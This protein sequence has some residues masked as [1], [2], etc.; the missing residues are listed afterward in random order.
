[1][2]LIIMQLSLDSR[3]FLLFKSP[4]ERKPIHM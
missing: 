2:N 3:Q 4:V 1:M